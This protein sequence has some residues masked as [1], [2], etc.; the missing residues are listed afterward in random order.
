MQQGGWD[1]SVATATLL[2]G[3]APRG[4]KYFGKDMWCCLIKH[5]IKNPEPAFLSVKKKKVSLDQTVEN[6]E[7]FWAGPCMS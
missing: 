5:T 7:I 2:S 4:V 3:T 1:I 6:Q